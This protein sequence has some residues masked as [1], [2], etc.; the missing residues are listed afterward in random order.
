V[1]L[2]LVN[3]C[4]KVVSRKGIAGD[5]SMKYSVL[6]VSTRGKAGDCDTA[7][8]LKSFTTDLGLCLDSLTSW[9]TL[10]LVLARRSPRGSEKDTSRAEDGAALSPADR[11]AEE[12]PLGEMI[13]SLDDRI[14]EFIATIKTKMIYRI[15]NSSTGELLGMSLY[16]DSGNKFFPKLRLQTVWPS[17]KSMHAQWAKNYFS[18]TCETNPVKV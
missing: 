8:Q 7:N 17:S 9:E 16:K 14:P 15:E 12:V 1:A 4:I 3:T 11:V 10:W 18:T 13:K 2:D 6:Q 5:K